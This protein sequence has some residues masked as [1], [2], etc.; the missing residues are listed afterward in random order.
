MVALG[1]FD[2]A[3][4]KTY[5]D[6]LKKK[7]QAKPGKKAK[8]V[9]ISRIRSGSVVVETVVYIPPPDPGE[10]EEEEDDDLTAMTQSLTSA[11][12]ALFSEE[13]LAIAGDPD[14]LPSPEAV[15]VWARSCELKP[16]PCEAGHAAAGAAAR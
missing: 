15:Q 1:S 12:K 3:F 6:D 9:R 4:R 13:M 7:M 5:L 14:P 10:E 11:P 8:Q 2:K 16:E